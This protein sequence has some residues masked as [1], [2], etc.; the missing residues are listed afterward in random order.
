MSI[1]KH[2]I[3]RKDQR[4]FLSLELC[5]RRSYKRVTVLGDSF[6]RARANEAQQMQAHIYERRGRWLI[7]RRWERERENRLLRH[8]VDA[9]I[10]MGPTRT[11]ARYIR[12]LFMLP[13]CAYSSISFS[14]TFSS[15][16][17]FTLYTWMY[18][19]N[20]RMYMYYCNYLHIILIK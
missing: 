3:Y 8:L 9:S 11:W 12:L 14:L 10:S 1:N 2:S 19:V 5:S 13:D 15:T 18:K 20:I 16:R 7:H 17:I 4:V 6:L